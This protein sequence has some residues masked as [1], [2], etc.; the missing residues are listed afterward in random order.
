MLNITRFICPFVVIMCG[1]DLHSFT[2][3]HVLIRPWRAAVSRTEDRGCSVDEAM[4]TGSDRVAVVEAVDD[5]SLS[6]NTE[7][8]FIKATFHL[9]KM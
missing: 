5:Q 1:W 8:G 6:E 3:P 2:E 4:E 7:A 9:V